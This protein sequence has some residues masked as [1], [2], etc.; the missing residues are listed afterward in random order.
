MVKQL[1]YDRYKQAYNF[2]NHDV[3]H[4]LNDQRD[5]K[6]RMAY[7]ENCMDQYRIRKG[8]TIASIRMTDYLPIF[9]IKQIIGYI[10]KSLC[11]DC[12][13]D[14]NK[15]FNHSYKWTIP[16]CKPCRIKYLDNTKR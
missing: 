14:I 5:F 8:K 12:R 2:V 11:L 3:F 4:F 10:T 9:T 6:E 15:S 13:K 7:I 1:T 16:L